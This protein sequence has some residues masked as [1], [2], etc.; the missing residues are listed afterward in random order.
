MESVL[1]DEFLD[2]F[3]G[4]L[5]DEAVDMISAFLTLVE[6][7]RLGRCLIILRNRLQIAVL[8]VEAFFYV[9]PIGHE[10]F[11]LVA[12]HNGRADL[13]VVLNQLVIS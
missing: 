11:D 10:E 5:A 2:H 3:M 13:L 7:Q 9:H 6:V 4:D 8:H 12:V 1:L